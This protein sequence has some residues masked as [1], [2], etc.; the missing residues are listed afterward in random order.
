LVGEGFF[1]LAFE[2]FEQE[3]EFGGFDGVLVDIDA[4]DAARED[5][6]AFVGGEF[7]GDVGG[8]VGA[9]PAE[10]GAI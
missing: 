6:F 1:G 8:G 3:G 5:A 10:A 2:D 4:E 7:V 9:I